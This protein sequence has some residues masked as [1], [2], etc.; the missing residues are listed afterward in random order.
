M[1]ALLC[2]PAFRIIIYIPV[3]HIPWAGY[4]VFRREIKP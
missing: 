2:T 4:P 1:S 3:S